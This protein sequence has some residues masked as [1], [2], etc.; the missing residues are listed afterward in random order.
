MIDDQCAGHGAEVDQVV[1]VVIVPGQTRCF[2]RQNSSHATRADSR[3]QT[4]KAGTL[5][6]ASSGAAQIFIDD[7][8]PLEAERLRPFSQ[9]ILASLS[10]QARAHL[11]H[12]RLADID[13][14]LAFN[15]TRLDFLAHRSPPL[16]W[17][18]LCSR[19]L[20]ACD[21]A[22]RGNAA[23][24]LAETPACEESPSEELPGVVGS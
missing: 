24:W 20:A 2:E 18:G 15:V 14:G 8:Y 10:F 17:S 19:L 21:P 12:R 5:Y 23:A 22:T 9:I 3:Q 1:P 4:A 6:G 13:I 16:C 7:N 11:L